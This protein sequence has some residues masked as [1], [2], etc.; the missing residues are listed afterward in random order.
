[1]LSS[2]FI[3]LLAVW[4][5]AIASPGPDTLQIMRQGLK[6]RATGVYCAIGIMVGNTLWILASLAG[7]S[8]LVKTHPAVMQV[9]H[10]AGGAYLLYLGLKMCWGGLTALRRR[11][12]G[13]Q[14]VAASQGLA[15]LAAVKLGLATNLANPKAILFFGAVFSTFTV[16]NPLLA[17]AAMIATGLA[18]FVGFALLVAVIA[19]RLQ[20]AGA[21]IDTLAGGLFAALGGTLIATAA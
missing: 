19:P 14:V 20:R 10:Y 13:V 5:A 2:S 17:A 12:A 9:L 8:A 21:V 3:S 11:G 18:W 16:V 6:T 15:P 1:M 4:L 7:L